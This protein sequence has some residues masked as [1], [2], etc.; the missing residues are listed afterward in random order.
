MITTAIASMQTQFQEDILKGLHRLCFTS[1]TPEDS[2]LTLTHDGVNLI[3]AMFMHSVDYPNS[4]LYHQ[5]GQAIDGLSIRVPALR[6]EYDN[7]VANQHIHASNPKVTIK[8]RFRSNQVEILIEGLYFPVEQYIIDEPKKIFIQPW[9][10]YYKGKTKVLC[11]LTQ[12]KENRFLDG[13]SEVLC[14]K[15]PYQIASPYNVPLYDLIHPK[16]GVVQ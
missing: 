12:T 2:W 3:R 7:F 5:V 1:T 14:K 15:L 9:Y 13:L 11:I 8:T 6:Y 16:K 4:F 10:D